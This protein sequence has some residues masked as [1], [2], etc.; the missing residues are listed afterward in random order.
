MGAVS[1]LLEFCPIYLR[2]IARTMQAYH[3]YLKQT[4]KSTASFSFWVTSLREYEF[5]R[6]FKADDDRR[7][8]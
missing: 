4:T 1:K 8:S 6:H 5:L 7:P 3:F 2:Y